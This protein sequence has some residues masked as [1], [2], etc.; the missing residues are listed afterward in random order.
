M[1]CYEMVREIYNACSGNQMRD[2]SIE[3]VALADPA[4]YVRSI[5]KGENVKIEEDLLSDGTIVLHVECAGLL[6][7]FSFTEL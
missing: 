2:V 1:K 6:Q 3:E 4:A 5:V 7:Q